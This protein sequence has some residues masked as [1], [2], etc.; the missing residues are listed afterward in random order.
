ML[1]GDRNFCTNM[2]ENYASV[3]EKLFVWTMHINIDKYWKQLTKI[4]ET[5]WVWLLIF[6]NYISWIIFNNWKRCICTFMAASHY[7]KNLCLSNNDTTRGV[8]PY[9]L[10]AQMRHIRNRGERFFGSWGG[11]TKNIHVL[12]IVMLKLANGFSDYEQVPKGARIVAYCPRRL[13]Q[14]RWVLLRWL[15]AANACIVYYTQR[16][17]VKVTSRLGRETEMCNPTVGMLVWAERAVGHV[18]AL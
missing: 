14:L 5:K 17:N 7:F 9:T 6:L 10:V 13:L 4:R 1:C 18:G 16:L 12:M 8:Y 11:R 2:H 15:E 3:T